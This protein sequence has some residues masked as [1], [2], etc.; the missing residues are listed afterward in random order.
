MESRY[1]DITSVLNKNEKKDLI[2][3]GNQRD[4]GKEEGY[5]L[6][7]LDAQFEIL[8]IYSN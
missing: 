2:I 5:F 4:V 3:P 8:P 7:E 6:P 1:T